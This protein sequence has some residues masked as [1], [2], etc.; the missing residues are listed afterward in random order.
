MKTFP[1]I[2]SGLVSLLKDQFPDKCPRSDPGA[3]GLGRL[4][5]QQE[6]IDLISHHFEK[7]KEA[8]FVRP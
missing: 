5:G 8:D 3:F 1:S 7:Q 4:T 2:P 6:V